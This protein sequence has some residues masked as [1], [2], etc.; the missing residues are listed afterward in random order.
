MANSSG[1]KKKPI[2]GFEW[3]TTR[4]C[5]MWKVTARDWHTS[6]QMFH[7]HFKSRNQ[8][9]ADLYEEDF[10]IEFAAADRPSS[11]TAT[12]SIFTSSSI[13]TRC[14][15]NTA[16]W[17]TYTDILY[18]LSDFSFL[19]LKKKRHIRYAC[20]WESVLLRWK[21]ETQWSWHDWSEGQLEELVKTQ[22]T[23]WLGSSLD[24]NFLQ[25]WTNLI[26]AIFKIKW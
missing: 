10:V 1:G 24:A 7:T 5:F 9:S 2:L 26:T 17:K 20:G 11:T 22:W 12:S 21:S 6:N 18:T 14:F 19:P 4:E 15:Q 25:L 13:S 16:L 23:F 8:P 3:M